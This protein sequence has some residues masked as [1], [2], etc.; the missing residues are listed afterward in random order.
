[1]INPLDSLF[2]IFVVLH[3]EHCN[4][5]ERAE[6]MDAAGSCFTREHYEMF[7]RAANHVGRIL[8]GDALTSIKV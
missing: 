4:E 2:E 6:F 8:K 3:D 7:R 5:Y 1:M